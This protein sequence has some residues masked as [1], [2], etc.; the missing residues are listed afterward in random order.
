MKLFL[1]IV[2][3][4]FFLLCTQRVG[5]AYELTTHAGLTDFEQ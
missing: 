1:K 2:L 5:R 4:S 3:L